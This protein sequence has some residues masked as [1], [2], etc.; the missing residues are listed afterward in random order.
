MH[1][2]LKAIPPETS[3]RATRRNDR[4]E[5][6]KQNRGV[7]LL[8]RVESTGAARHHPAFARIQKASSFNAIAT[9]E[10]HRCL[11]ATFERL[12]GPSRQSVIQLVSWFFD[13][14]VENKS[15]MTVPVVA[16]AA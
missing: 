6:V 1:S 10:Q 7:C 9:S 12:S 8:G 5:D 4:L 15:S 3:D 13:R 2:I 11:T 14:L 16:L